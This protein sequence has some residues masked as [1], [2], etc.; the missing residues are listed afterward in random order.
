MGDG[1][2][3]GLLGSGLPIIPLPGFG[4][5]A[6]TGEAAVDLSAEAQKLLSDPRTYILGVVFE[7]FVGG[8]VDGIARL[9]GLFADAFG[10]AVDGVLLPFESA[11]RAFAPIGATLVS[12]ITLL[13]DLGMGLAE[14]A[15]PFA[16]IVVALELYVVILAFRF[17][18]SMLLDAVP[19]LGAFAGVVR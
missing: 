16:P 15:G 14:V 10:L 18:A 3:G 8:I 4:T 7:V 2:S 12:P 17:G 11:V 5:G 13:F 9:L 19:G 1:D 6:K